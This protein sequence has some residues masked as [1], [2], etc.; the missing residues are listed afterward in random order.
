MSGHY[1]LSKQNYGYCVRIKVPLTIQKQVGL[2]EIKYSL[3]TGSIQ[4]A[5]QKAKQI[6]TK[7]KLLFGSLQMNDEALTTM[8]ITQ[9]EIRRLIAEYVSEAVDLSEQRISSQR[10][11]LTPDDVE[12][13]ADIVSS[14]KYD[15]QEQ[16]SYRN[17]RQAYHKV[18]QLISTHK[19][20]ISKGSN[21]YRTL[22]REM[23]LGML[24]LMDVELQQTVGDYTYRQRKAQETSLSEAHETKLDRITLGELTK[25][26]WSEQSPHWK[27]RTVTEQ[28]IFNESLLEFIGSVA[29]VSSVTYQTGRDYK[30]HIKLKKGRGGKKP[31]SDARINMYLGYA[32]A[33]FSFAKRHNYIKD[34][35]FEGLQIRGKKI[36]ADKIRDIFTTDDLRLMFCDSKEYGQDK[37]QHPHNFWVP[38]LA[39]FTGCRLEEL[40][41]L[42]V[43]DIRVEDDIYYLD[44]NQDQK[45]KSVKTDEVRQVP[46]HPFIIKDLKFP[47][48]YIK[49]LRPNSRVFPKLKYINNRYGHAVGQWFARFKKNAGI[50]AKPNTKVFHSF[51]HNLSTNL[52]YNMVPTE[53]IDEL[54]GHATPGEQSRYGKRYTVKQLYSGALLKLDYKIDLSHLRQSRFVLRY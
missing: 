50:I 42:R 4:Q 17:Y 34:N 45:R 2:T 30:N 32:S 25:Q 3:K 23:M 8:T 20:N 22:A 12:R 31:L 19:L 18:D 41:Q 40:C 7:V 33:V 29:Q 51:R 46:L 47:P 28:E 6:V 48:E 1:Y 39:L 27:P 9:T 44:I 24:E 38:L 13:Q 52:K 21:E 11:I 54:T 37:C 15:L 49:S 43:S 5:K 16:L 26:Y 53:M 14:L 10:G 36:R 35:P